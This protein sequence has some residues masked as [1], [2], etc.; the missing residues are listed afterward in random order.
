MAKVCDYI[1][2]RVWKKEYRPI[3]HDNI[4]E[5]EKY[6]GKV[7]GGGKSEVVVRWHPLFVQLLERIR[8]EW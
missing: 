3:Y 1:I 4:T 7:G 2:P 6:R 8:S 5:N